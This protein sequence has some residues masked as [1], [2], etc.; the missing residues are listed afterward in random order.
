MC[1]GLYFPPAPP[2]TTVPGLLLAGLGS[3]I[4]RHPSSPLAVDAPRPWALHCMKAAPLAN[5]PAKCPLWLQATPSSH[6][7][8][9]LSLPHDVP[10]PGPNLSTRWAA[11][12]HSSS[13]SPSWSPLLM[14]TITRPLGKGPVRIV[15]LLPQFPSFIY[16]LAEAWVTSFYL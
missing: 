6:L 5:L 13:Q 9:S 2:D 11:L 8:P 15:N 3:P 10:T 7:R 1:V 12:T 14:D 4:C 16:K